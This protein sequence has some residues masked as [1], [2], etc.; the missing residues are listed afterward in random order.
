MTNAP[1]RGPKDMNC[2]FFQQ[3]QS[4]VCDTCAL[5]Q[6]WKVQHPQKANQEID[7]WRCSFA[8]MPG[9]LMNVA[10][11]VVGVQQAA[12]SHRNEY[13]ERHDKAEQR[14]AALVQRQGP[15]AIK[16]IEAKNGS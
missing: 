8:W 7:E 14:L 1:P 2:P 11:E 12:E 3:P 16:T 5:W 6:P 4:E 13:C 15:P 9:M 10:R